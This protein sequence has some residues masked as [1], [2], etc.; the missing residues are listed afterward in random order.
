MTDN[1]RDRI[2]AACKHCGRAIHAGSPER[3]YIHRS[4]GYASKS[5]CDPDESGL[6]YGY[7]AEPVGQP[8]KSPCVGATRGNDE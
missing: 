5:R 8:C 1:L 6:P 7:N 2:A 4:D 3:G